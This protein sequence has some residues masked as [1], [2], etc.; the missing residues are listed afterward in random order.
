M[1]S[2]GILDKVIGRVKE[3]AGSLMD[4][5]ALRNEGRADQKT[6]EAKEKSDE[7]IES[8]R[9]KSEEIIDTAKETLGGSDRTRDQA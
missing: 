9:E 3:A 2:S 8:A 5:D 4:D 7:V 6:G 1:S